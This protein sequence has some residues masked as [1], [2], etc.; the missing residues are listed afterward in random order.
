MKMMILVLK[1]VNYQT[2]K[3][4]QNVEH[5]KKIKYNHNK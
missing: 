5:P 4:F 2:T 3:D 1:T